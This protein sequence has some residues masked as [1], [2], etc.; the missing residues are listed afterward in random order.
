[1]SAVT[2][3]A[4]SSQEDKADSTQAPRDKSPSVAGW[5]QK[6]LNIAMKTSRKS[7]LEILVTR[8]P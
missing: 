5:P 3:L 1:M 7:A 8:A 4:G 2:Q 6:A